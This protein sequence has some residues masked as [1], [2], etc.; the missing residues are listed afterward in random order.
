MLKKLFMKLFCRKNQKET[1]KKVP[2]PE[3]VQWEQLKLPL[4]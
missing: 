2:V 1:K 3:K 4:D